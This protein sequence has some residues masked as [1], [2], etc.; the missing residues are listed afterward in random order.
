MTRLLSRAIAIGRGALKSF[1][2]NRKIADSN[3]PANTALSGAVLR[4]F[5]RVSASAMEP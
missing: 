2:K 3:E 4:S 1:S 5:G